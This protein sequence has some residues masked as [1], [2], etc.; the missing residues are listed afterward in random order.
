MKTGGRI[1]LR[2]IEYKW[3]CALKCREL[4]ECEET[5][6]KKRGNDLCIQDS[7]HLDWQSV[8][9]HN[10]K[11]EVSLAKGHTKG[12]QNQEYKQKQDVGITLNVLAWCLERSSFL[13]SLK[14][15]L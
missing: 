8:S 3:T 7:Q 15:D 10:A 1:F 4:H 11:E 6:G 9:G 12:S 13:R 14:D 2:C 5:Q